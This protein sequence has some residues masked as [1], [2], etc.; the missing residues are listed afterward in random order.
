MGTCLV[1]A[2]VKKKTWKMAEEISRA[3]N[4]LSTNKASSERFLT[5]IVEDFFND[6]EAEA[7]T[8]VDAPCSLGMCTLQPMNNYRYCFF[9]KKKKN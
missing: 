9:I 6:E 3:L 2:A 7:E 5:G 1:V 4:R 8:E